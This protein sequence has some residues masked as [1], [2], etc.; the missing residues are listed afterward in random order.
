[1]KNFKESLSQAI[2]QSGGLVLGM[3]DETNDLG[4]DDIEV[5]KSEYIDNEND[6]MIEE[7]EK[8]NVADDIS[9]DALTLAL[10]KDKTAPYDNEWIEIIDD[11]SISNLK[12]NDYDIIAFKHH[13]DDGFFI[14]EA[15]YE[16]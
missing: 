13:T 3:E 6:M 9:P 7:R 11:S 14:T 10:P 16:E 8:P 4:D 15:A 5:P 2:E 1:M 12:F